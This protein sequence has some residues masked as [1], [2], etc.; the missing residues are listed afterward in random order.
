MPD[1]MLT[2]EEVNELS[3]RLNRNHGEWDWDKLAN[4]WELDE[5]VAWGFNLD[6]LHLDMDSKKEKP[7]DESCK[8]PTCGKKMKKSLDA[9]YP[10]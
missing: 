9:S 6:E 5:L 7:Q 3:I 2:K 1:R 4:E 8:C 10:S